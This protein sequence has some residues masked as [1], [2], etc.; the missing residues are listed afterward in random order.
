MIRIISIFSCCLALASCSQSVREIGKEPELSPVGSGMRYTDTSNI[1]VYPKQPPRRTS[2]HSL[3]SDDKSSLF[4]D[5]RAMGVGDIL[6]VDISINDSA[7]F[8]NATNRSRNS[9]NGVNGSGSAGSLPFF[10]K[11]GGESD[12]TFG[13]DAQSTGN[14]TTNR[15]EQLQI[16]VAAVVTDILQ[17]GNLVISGSQE[18]RVNEEL[19]ILNVTGIVRPK[20]ID[21]SNMISYQKIA[22][23]RISYGGRGRLSEVQKPPLSQQVFD[24]TAPLWELPWL[25]K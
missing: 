8:A 11:R 16:M 24:A 1:T 21:S 18:V 22:E 19:R 3:W 23:A 5:T 2:L 6:T 12:L 4:Q 17:N 14:G 13:S 7:N 25:M 10:G 15:S 9:S 20:D